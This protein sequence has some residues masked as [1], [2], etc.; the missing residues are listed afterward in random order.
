MNQLRQHNPCN[1]QIA[2]FHGHD[3]VHPQ[4]FYSEAHLDTLG[5]CFWLAVIKRSDPGA[6]IVLDDVFTSV[7]AAHLG[8]ID[9]MLRSE[10][11]S[12]AQP[13]GTFAQIIVV[14][15]YRGWLEKF[16]AEMPND[17][18]IKELIRWT[19]THGIRVHNTLPHTAELRA[20]LDTPYLDRQ[21]VAS[22]AGVILEQLLDD[23]T[24]TLSMKFPRTSR[25]E[26]TLA[27]LL[28]AVTSST[29]NFTTQHPGSPDSLPWPPALK[30]LNDLAFIRNQVGAHFNVAALD[31]SD[32][33]VIELGEATLALAHLMT[34]PKCHERAYR[35]D[36]RDRT[37][38]C[39]GRCQQTRIQTA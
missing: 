35:K 11:K 31:V 4:G 32:Q 25:G 22:Q 6:I 39:G 28:E 17:V 19:I 1:H 29:K 16:R 23:L 10:I 30:R 27:P 33:D 14:T 36:H 12:R 20:K 2:T 13:E 21:G 3:D 8:R 37:F 34:C 9:Q 15:H 26:Y 24:V 5:F 18:D 7:D 38:F